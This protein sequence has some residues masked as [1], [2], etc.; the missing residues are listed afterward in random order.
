M[1][2]AKSEAHA[3]AIKFLTVS[4]WF[5][6]ILLPIVFVAIKMQ[7][8]GLLVTTGS[9]LLFSVLPSYFISGLPFYEW[10]ETVMMCGVY[11]IGRSI[12]ML[13]RSNPKERG[14]LEGPFILYWGFLIKYAHPIILMFILVATCAGDTGGYGGYAIHWQ[15]A[16]IFVPAVGLIAFILFIFCNVYEENYDKSEFDEQYFMDTAGLDE[17]KND[18]ENE[19]AAIDP[20]AAKVS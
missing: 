20:S 9:M 17:L 14:K 16:G 8:A 7:A 1:N 19:L 5:L 11:R 6:T 15:I 2:M 10:Y 4:Y 3:K 13:G 12:I 18:K